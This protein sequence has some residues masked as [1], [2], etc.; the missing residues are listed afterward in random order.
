MKAFLVSLLVVSGVAA[1]FV[2]LLMS[3]RYDNNYT[4]HYVSNG[5]FVV[6]LITMSAGI[7]AMTGAS[8]IFL[9]MGYTIKNIFKKQDL[10]FRE[11]LEA[12]EER[13]S[14]N[15]PYVGVNLFLVGLTMVVASFMF[16]ARV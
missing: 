13:K 15:K 16:A 2:I 14:T 8:Q 7:L 12:R 6:G 10:K 4:Y 5:L 3:M 9:A 11:Y 1:T